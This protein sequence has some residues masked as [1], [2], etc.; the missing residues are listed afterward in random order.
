M[1]KFYALSDPTRHKII[2]MLAHQGPLK[3]TEICEAFQISPQGISQHLKVLREAELVRVEK[4][5]QQRIYHINADALL[6]VENWARQMTQMWDERF[7]ALD[8]MLQ[9]AQE[10]LKGQP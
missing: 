7:T 5:A 4:R 8:R 10:K 6:E 2:E 3:A 9:E 1:D